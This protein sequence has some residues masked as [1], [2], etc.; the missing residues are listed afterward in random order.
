M[1]TGASALTT[2]MLLNQGRHFGIESKESTRDLIMLLVEATTGT[3]LFPIS[4]G[5]LQSTDV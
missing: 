4:Y 3:S 5:G 1:N 2:L